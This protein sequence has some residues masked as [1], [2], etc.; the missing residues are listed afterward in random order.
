MQSRHMVCAHEPLKIASS[1]Q[2]GMDGVPPRFSVN[3]Q[4][5]AVI[6]TLKPLRRGWSVPPVVDDGLALS[7]LRDQ[8]SSFGE[9][10]TA[11]ARR[12]R[13]NG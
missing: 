8:A 7:E 3:V 10:Q 2:E 9:F 4:C 5:L 1:V 11:N 13:A 12:P 6:E